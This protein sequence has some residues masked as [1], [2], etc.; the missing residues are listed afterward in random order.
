MGNKNPEFYSGHIGKEFGRN[1]SASC[2]RGT[3]AV[4]FPGPS[5]T[6]TPKPI[7]TIPTPI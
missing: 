6:V 3:E 1:E 7:I 4:P 5:S 2:L